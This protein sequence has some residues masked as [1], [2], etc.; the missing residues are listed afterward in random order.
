MKASDSEIVYDLLVVGGGIQGAW[1]ALEAARTGRKVALLERDDFGAGTSAN[2]LKVLHGGLRYLQHGN[3]KRIRESRRSVKAFRAVAGDWIEEVPFF[4][5]TK[6]SGV[7]GP[8]AMR[9]AFG[10]FGLLSRIWGD[11]G[12]GPQGRV[13]SGD[14]TRQVP[15]GVFSPS[16]NGVA[17]WNEAVMRNSERIVFEVVR[18]AERCGADCLNYCEVSAIAKVSERWAARVVDRRTG[19]SGTVLANQVVEAT[20][21]R[22]EEEVGNEALSLLRGVNLVF[23]G[24]PFGTQAVG[25]E[26]RDA[27]HDLDALVKRGNRLLFFVPRGDQTM[28]GTWYD[29]LEDASAEVTENDLERWLEEIHSV[30]PDLGFHRRNLRYIH[31]GLLPADERNEL[32]AQPAKESAILPVTA[33]RFAVRTVKFTTAPEMARATLE[34]MGFELA[35]RLAPTKQTEPP[36]P[37]YPW[38]DL[39]RSD[40]DVDPKVLEVAVR[41]EKVVHLDDA[42]L[43]RSNVALDDFCGEEKF[44]LAATRLGAMLGWDETRRSS[45]VT[46]VLDRL[47]WSKVR[48]SVEQ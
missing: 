18:A 14:P 22:V 48:P 20:G 16:A 46:R 27:S 1:L 32:S 43:R 13:F 5:E 34:K 9:G 33:G 47:R 38:E 25:L 23:Q 12:K 3:L 29:R 8:W 17:R 4:L 2:S 6:G 26:S 11:G 36:P 44:I 39:L 7:R 41:E 37:P 42:L 28:V 30:A 31:S 40:V 19:E 45:E 21:P 10:L 35:P 24:T 15:G